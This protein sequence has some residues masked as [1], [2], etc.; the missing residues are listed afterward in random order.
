MILFLPFFLFFFLFYNTLKNHNDDEAIS[1]KEKKK[2][3]KHFV[4]ISFVLFQVENLVREQCNILAE[5]IEVEI[6]LIRNI[7]A[8]IEPNS[9]Q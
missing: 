2:S 8:P 4:T 6:L 7:I 1:K 5:R 9:P 3:I